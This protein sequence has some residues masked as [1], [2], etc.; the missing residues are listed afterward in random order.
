MPI[1]VFISHSSADKDLAEALIRLLRAAL[2]LQP[3]SIRCTSVRGYKLPTGAEVDAQLRNEVVEAATFVALL[4]KASLDSTYVLFELGARWGIKKPLFPL[5]ARG[6]TGGALDGPLRAINARE[7][8]SPEEVY[9]FLAEMADSLKVEHF[10]PQVFQPELRAFIASATENLQPSKLTAATQSQ[11]GV[12]IIP[13]ANVPVRGT[14]TL[15]AREICTK[16]RDAAPLQ[17]EEMARGFIG[18]TVDWETTF[19]SAYPDTLGAG[20]I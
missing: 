10:R 16:L 15:S 7:C 17:V 1:K 3:D 8:G 18:Y 2:A 12:A 13:V 9:Q 5:L 6:I 20:T 4:T 14:L 19:S 11:P